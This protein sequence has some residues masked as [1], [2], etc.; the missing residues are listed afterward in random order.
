MAKYLFFLLLLILGL[1]ATREGYF[2]FLDRQKLPIGTTIGEIPVD[3]LSLQEAGEKVAEAYGQP[4]RLVNDLSGDNLDLSPGEVGFTLDLASMLFEAEEAMNAQE[5]WV[6]YLGYLLD[7]PLE[8]IE[9]ELIAVHDDAAV[10][11]VMRV[12]VDLMENRAVPPR[13]E[14]ESLRV[15]EGKAGYSADLEQ[16][17]AG[18]V[19]ALY[20]P[21]ERTVEFAVVYE[22]APPLTIDMLGSVIDDILVQYP[23]YFAA[24]YIVDLET[25]EEYGINSDVAVSGLS[26]MKIPILIETYRVINGVPNFEIQN[27]MNGM[28]LD[29]SNYTSNLLLD[30]VA[31]QDN[32]YLGSDILTESMQ[33][34]GLANT[35]LVTP[36][37]EPPRPT[38]SWLKTPANQNPDLPT[39][40]EAAMQTTAED[41]GTLISTIY[42]CTQDGGALRALYPDTVTAAECQAMLD[43]LSLNI[44]CPCLRGGVPPTVRVSHKHGY[45]SDIHGDGGI[46]FS[47]G[48]DYVLVMYVSDPGTDW[49][50]ADVTFPLM[51]QVSRIA[52]NYFNFEDQYLEPLYLDAAFRPEDLA[53]AAAE[54]AAAAAAAEAAAAEAAAAEESTDN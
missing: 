14:P 23:A 7:R 47:D 40:P 25:G 28:I 9:V 48:G 49:L 11:D 3:S 22:D 50:L 36:Y 34:L 18:L 6:G 51:G 8:P 20:Q 29:S 4:V 38:R 19:N 46:V 45:G 16:T 5:W 54:E 41:M 21:T 37:E 1:Y 33:N 30:V 52:Y 43:L 44:H 17:R 12:V 32:A 24:V 15:L 13:V 53:R 10:D 31:G 26:M 39:I 42:A 35:Y 2:Y 27:L